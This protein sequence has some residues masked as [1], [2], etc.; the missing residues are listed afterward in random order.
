MT[1]EAN[2]HHR[3]GQLE[4]PTREEEI[5]DA[6]NNSN[7]RLAATLLRG[8]DYLSKPFLIA[9]ADMLDGNPKVDPVLTQRYSYRLRLAPWG[10]R[11]RKAKGSRAQPFTSRQKKSKP[12]PSD[13]MLCSKVKR[14]LLAEPTLTRAAAVAAVAKENGLSI[15]LVEKA[16]DTYRSKLKTSNN[17]KPTK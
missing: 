10:I 14:R 1:S 3:E 8:S 4:L 17:A 2:Q 7:S 6:L 16:Y 11:G 13:A 12:H 5:I 15:S 9:L